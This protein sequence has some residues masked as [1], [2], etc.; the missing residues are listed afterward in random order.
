MLPGSDIKPELRRFRSFRPNKIT[1]RVMLLLL[2]FIGVGWLFYLGPGRPVLEGIL[3]NLVQNIQP[4]PLVTM[5]VTNP[6]QVLI[7]PSPT[8]RPL[9]N[10]TPTPRPLSTATPTPIPD[11]PTVEASPTIESGCVDVLTITL[12]D[13]GK[14]LC[15]RGIIQ[16][17]ETRPSGFL[18]A[19][20]SQRGAMYWISYDLVWMPAKEG[21]CVENTGEV[22]QIANSPVLVFGY[23]NQPSIC[24]LP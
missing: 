9:S 17:F 8:S 10:S 2:I 14:T 3:N 12:E 20:S 22:M 24:S 15:I 18:I 21:L 4:K 6:T 23:Q 7:E 13:V 11:T 5:V 19:F 16:N 1:L